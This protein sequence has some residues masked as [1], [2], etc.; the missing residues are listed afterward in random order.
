MSTVL[1]LLLADA[2]LPAAGHTQSG[3]L[4]PGLADGLD[5]HNLPAYVRSRLAT[6]VRTEATT[7]VVARHHALAGSSLDPV[8][9]AWAA[10]TPSDAMRA[11]ARTLGRGLLRLARRT[12]PA[13]VAGWAPDATPPRAVVLGAVAAGAGLSAVE[14][15]R[16]VAYDDTQTV[17]SAALKLLP[18]DPADATAWCVEL[19]PDVDRL[20]HEVSTLTETTDIPATGSPQI[21]AWAQAH[22]RATRR[23]FSA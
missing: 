3:G 10:R 15:A 18:L 17:L 21:E 14:L 9:A 20:A 1:A 23:L 22:A 13:A 11:T 12:W 16:V 19:L 5:P 4:E 6:V 8:E 7:A 2:R